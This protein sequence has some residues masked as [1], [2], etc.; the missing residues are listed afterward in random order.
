MILD[1]KRDLLMKV[2][3]EQVGARD[4]C[5]IGARPRHMAKAE[6]AVDLDEAGRGQPDFGIKGAD[7]GGWLARA[8]HAAELLCQKCGRFLVKRF[9]P[10][11]CGGW[12]GKGHRGRKLRRQNGQAGLFD[13]RTISI[14]SG[15]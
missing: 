7:A 13:H 3:S 8:D 5:G 2:I 11:H 14:V 6:A 4:G 12:I 1:Q 10:R 9:Q 15:I